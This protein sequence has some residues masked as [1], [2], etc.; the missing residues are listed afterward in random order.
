MRMSDL[1]SEV[2]GQHLVSTLMGLRVL[3]IQFYVTNS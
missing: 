3:D 1:F 2:R